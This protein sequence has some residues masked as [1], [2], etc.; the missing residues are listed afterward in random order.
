MVR[1]L[2]HSNVLS[3]YGWDD[4]VVLDGLPGGIR[5]LDVYFQRGRAS[6]VVEKSD[7]LQMER[8]CGE[9]SRC[10]KGPRLTPEKQVM[11]Y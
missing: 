7:L 9:F 11:Y 6:A 10:L 3:L 8:L 2:W 5:L 4:R 1:M